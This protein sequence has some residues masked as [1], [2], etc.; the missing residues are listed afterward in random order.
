MVDHMEP[1]A[2]A[3][4]GGRVMAEAF[5]HATALF[6]DV[7]MR[8]TRRATHFPVTAEGENEENLRDGTHFPRSEDFVMSPNFARDLAKELL[9]AARMAEKNRR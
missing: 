6:C 4:Q 2:P 5:F 3:G 7:V 9:K 8:G 1:P